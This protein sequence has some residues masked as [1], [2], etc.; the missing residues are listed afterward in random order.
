MVIWCGPCGHKI[1]HG[2]RGLAWISTPP[3]VST[4][5]SDLRRCV[6]GGYGQPGPDTHFRSSTH[7]SP[8]RR[9]LVDLPSDAAREP[10]AW[11]RAYVPF[12]L[13]RE[14][15]GVRAGGWAGVVA[16]KEHPI[17]PEVRR[18]LS[19]RVCGPLDEAA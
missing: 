7:P 19:A 9:S 17:L 16:F 15:L 1:G 3:C 12:A 6:T 14:A 10:A 5:S 18:D 8:S 2:D 4:T 13:A 11:L